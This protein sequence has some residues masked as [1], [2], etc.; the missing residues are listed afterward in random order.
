MAAGGHITIEGNVAKG[1]EPCGTRSL[2]TSHAGR[3]WEVHAACI[4]TARRSSTCGA[5]SEQVDGGALGGEHHGAGALDHEGPRGNALAVFSRLAR[6]CRPQRGRRSRSAGCDHGPPNARVGARNA[7]GLSRIS[8]GF[9]QSELLWRFDPGHRSLGQF[10]QEVIASS[11]GIDFYIRLPESI[12]N[13]RLAK[14]EQPSLIARLLGLPIR[15]Q[16]EP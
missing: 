9:Y 10:F 7:A 1:C 8:L 2:R 3:S 11:L 5:G 4:A 6:A 14:L 13:S 15:L 12:P 16:L